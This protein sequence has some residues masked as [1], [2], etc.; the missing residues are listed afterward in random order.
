MRAFSLFIRTASPGASLLAL[1]SLVLLLVKILALNRFPELFKGAQELGALLE[2]IL[3][4]VVASYVFYLMLVHLKERSDRTVVRPYVNKHSRRVVA[5]CE[6]Q[7]SELGKAAAIELALVST[8]LIETSTA[9]A[10][11]PM[12]TPAPLVLTPDLRKAKWL[13]YFSYFSQ[14]SRASIARVLTQLPYIEARLVSLLTSIDDC[15]HFNS[16]DLLKGVPITDG[17]LAGFASSFYKYCEACR[18]LDQYLQEDA[19]DGLVP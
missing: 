5:D 4:S 7:L 14:R 16:M 3:A 9:F 1:F 6:M 11:I 18:A 19:A 15:P 10:K 12:S 13:E 17:T 8:T 2:S